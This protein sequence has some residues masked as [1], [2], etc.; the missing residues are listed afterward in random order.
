LEALVDGFPL[1]DRQLRWL[2]RTRRGV[3]TCLA[4]AT[5]NSVHYLLGRPLLGTRHSKAATLQQG[6]N[7]HCHGYSSKHVTSNSKLKRLIVIRRNS[8]SA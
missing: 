2:V 3:D 8:G 6:E 1:L 7:G 5:S 4:E